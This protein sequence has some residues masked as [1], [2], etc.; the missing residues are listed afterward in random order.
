M[1]P[2]QTNFWNPRRE[3]KRGKGIRNVLADGSGKCVT[4]YPI[5]DF[6]YEYESNPNYHQAVTNN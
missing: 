4:R 3:E 1:L 5:Q 6:L 2:I